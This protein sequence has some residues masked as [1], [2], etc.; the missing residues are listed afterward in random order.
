MMGAQ[1]TES[2]VLKRG[3]AQGKQV[4]TSDGEFLGTIEDV[5]TDG[6][7]IRRPGGDSPTA[8][9]PELWIADIDDRV[10]LNRTGAEAAAGWQAMQFKKSDKPMPE[11]GREKPQRTNSVT[12]L[13]FLALVAI[14][15]L[16]ILALLM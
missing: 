5:A 2:V 1:L 7:V 11:T 13:I 6:F 4:L 16:I 8:P 12:W 9:L 3:T 10:H 14:M 15:L